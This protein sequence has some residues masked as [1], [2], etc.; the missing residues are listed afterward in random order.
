[1]DTFIALAGVLP[2]LMDFFI[3]VMGVLFGLM[4][5]I[6]ILMIVLPIY[7]SMGLFVNKPEGLNKSGIH[8]FTNLEPGEIKILERGQAP[9]RMIMDVAGKHFARTKS[10]NDPEYWKLV[11]GETEDPT[12]DI[13]AP[14]RWWAQIVYKRTRLVFTGIYPFQKVRERE[15][16]RT[17]VDRQEVNRKSGTNLSLD[18]KK[19]VSDHFRARQFLFPVHVTA[20]ETKDKIPLDIIGIAEMEVTN[21]HMAAYGTDRWDQAMINLITDAIVGVM[22]KMELDHALTSG[23]D[24][25]TRMISQTVEQITA[26]QIKCG[27]QINAFRILEINPVLD[28]EGLR[29]IQSEALASQKAKATRIDGGA[30]ADALRSLNEA[31]VAGGQ[32]SIETMRAE[33]LVRAAEAAGKNGGSVILMPGGTGRQ[34]ADPTQVAILAELKKLSRKD[35]T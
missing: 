16:E 14:I 15:I 34:E 35:R 7:G 3:A 11:S 23:N 6:L 31:N 21:P 8:F 25:D 2:G 29:A 27:I 5:C 1:M 10:P 22:K 24:A 4:A 28:D 26:D 32:H 17:T 12:A 18:V 9:V 33:A 30:R 19:D 20:A 13:W